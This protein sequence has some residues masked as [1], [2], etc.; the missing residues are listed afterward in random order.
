MSPEECQVNYAICVKANTP[1][2]TERR[3]AGGRDGS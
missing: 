2:I 3:C 1:S